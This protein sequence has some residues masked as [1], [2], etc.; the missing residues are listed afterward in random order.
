MKSTTNYK[1]NYCKRNPVIS[2][3]HY[4]YNIHSGQTGHH[5]FCTNTGIGAVIH[6]Y[7]SVIYSIGYLLSVTACCRLPMTDYIGPISNGPKFSEQSIWHL[8][9]CWIKCSKCTIFQFSTF[10]ALTDVLEPIHFFTGYRIYPDIKF[11]RIMLDNR[12]DRMT[13]SC[14]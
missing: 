10:Y 8:P 14:P 1:L 9:K 13:R 12:F 6:T 4:V 3:D 2:D 11:L 5:Y 7:G